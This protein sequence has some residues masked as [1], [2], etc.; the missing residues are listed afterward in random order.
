MRECGRVEVFNKFGV[1]GVTGSLGCC[2]CCVLLI[3]AS[4]GWR[5]IEKGVTRC[6]TG[7]SDLPDTVPVL[8]GCRGLC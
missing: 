4:I 1:A 6:A 2:W 3:V 8:V 5:A 7:E